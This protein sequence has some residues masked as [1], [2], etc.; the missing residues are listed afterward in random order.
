MLRVVLDTNVVVSAHL[1]ADGYERFVLDLVLRRKLMLCVSQ[2]ILLEYEGVLRRAKFGI[3]PRNVTLSL[4]SIR[5]ANRMVRPKQRRTVSPDPDDNR[6]LE[7]A[8]T[9]KA[10]FLVTGNKRHFPKNWRQTKIVG[11]RELI[12]LI[13]P[14]L[15]R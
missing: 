14:D 15:K 5:N 6:F 11:A 9:A 7:C 4:Q 8:E 3:D 13:V 10:D 12:K 2:E 1:N